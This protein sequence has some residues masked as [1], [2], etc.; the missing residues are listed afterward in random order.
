MRPRPFTL[1]EVMIASLVLALSAVATMSI[2][3][4]SQAKVLREERRWGREHYLTNALEFYLACGPSADF[5]QELL[6]QGW[7]AECEL[8][9]VE[10]GLPD[11]AY[12]SIQGWR[13]GEFLVRLYDENGNLVGEQSIRKL[14]KNEDVGYE[15]TGGQG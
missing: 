7:R 4:T 9:N 8:F 12:E 10:E 15:P 5:P 13:L 11:A 3:G 1:M 2:V 14:V 6:P